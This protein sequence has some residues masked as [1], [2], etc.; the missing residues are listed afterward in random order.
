MLL[1]CFTCTRT[2]TEY[3]ALVP[4]VSDNERHMTSVVFCQMSVLSKI[5]PISC[6]ASMNCV[7][8]IGPEMLDGPLLYNVEHKDI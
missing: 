1:L 8:C 4:A 3:M 2:G 5:D 7:L 6:T